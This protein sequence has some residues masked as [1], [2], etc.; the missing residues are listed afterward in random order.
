[1]GGVWNN[2]IKKLNNVLK[3]NDSLLKKF[4]KNFDI[5]LQFILKKEFPWEN[6]AS[7]LS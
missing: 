1:M 6:T 2:I 4:E 7:V 5:V 3:L